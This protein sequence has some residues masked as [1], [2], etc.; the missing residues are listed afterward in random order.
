MAFLIN[1]QNLETV[2]ANKKMR[3]MYIRLEGSR[4]KFSKVSA[5][6]HSVYECQNV[7]NSFYFKKK[8]GEF[9]PE[10]Q[11]CTPQFQ[12]EWALSSAEQSGCVGGIASLCTQK[13]IRVCKWDGESLQ[14]KK[15][16]MWKRDSQCLP[17]RRT[18]PPSR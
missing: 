6:V 5:L 11:R 10:G 18:F 14:K 12:S 3:K 16:R 17:S 2:T 8:N 1:Y 13:K 4:H 9:V 15:I 7:D